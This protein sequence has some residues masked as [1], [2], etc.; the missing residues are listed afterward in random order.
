MRYRNDFRVQVPMLVF[1][2][3]FRLILVVLGFIFYPE[4]V[5]SFSGFYGF[6]GF[7]VLFPVF[8]GSF[9]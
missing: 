4:K 1:I 2:P 6:P 7:R 9:F 8:S 3:V 5:G